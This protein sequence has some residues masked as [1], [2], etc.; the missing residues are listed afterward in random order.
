M[1]VYVYIPGITCAYLHANC[2]I[3]PKHCHG[4]KNAFPSS[5]A[6][7]GPDLAYGTLKP[8]ARSAS[9]RQTFTHL[10]DS[11]SR[12]FNLSNPRR[13]AQLTAHVQS[14]GSQPLGAL[15]LADGLC[16]AASSSPNVEHCLIGGMRQ[17]TQF[18][19]RPP[20]HTHTHNN[21]DNV[22]S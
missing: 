8:S 10:T 17:S 20:T 4:C 3:K 19:T 2:Q 12:A 22:L 13:T 9:T 14:Q 21:D 15:A 7:K 11:A 1:R 5:T 18:Y 16:A 6:Q